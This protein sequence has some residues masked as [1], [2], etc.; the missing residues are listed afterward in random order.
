[1]HLTKENIHDFVKTKTDE[2]YN[3][4]VSDTKYYIKVFFDYQ[5]KNIFSKWNWAWFFYRKMYVK[6][7]LILFLTLLTSYYIPY[8]GLFWA[9]GIGFYGNYLYLDFL[10]KKKEAGYNN[11]GTNILV[12][13]CA[14]LLGM[15]VLG[16][17]IYSE[18]Q[19]LNTP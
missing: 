15:I 12:P 19:L 5:N 1:M 3:V 4:K 6:G 13:V 17:V 11:V 14:T 10:K 8:T 2:T 16:Y 9:I 18:I 7:T